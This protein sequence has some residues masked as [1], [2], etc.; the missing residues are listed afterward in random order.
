MKTL[1]KRS[2]PVLVAI[3]VVALAGDLALRFSMRRNRVERET[4]FETVVRPTEAKAREDWQRQ[5]AELE[6]DAARHPGAI[7]PLPKVDFRGVDVSQ[8]MTAIY[9]EPY[10]RL[11]LWRFAF[12]ATAVTAALLAVYCYAMLQ[13]VIRKKAQA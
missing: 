2:V 6:A 7:A 11:D 3:T 1:L 4:Y 10:Y 9:D 8:R 13:A 5:R 12:E